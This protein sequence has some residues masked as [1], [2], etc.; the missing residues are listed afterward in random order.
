MMVMNQHA[1]SRMEH[2]PTLPD[3]FDA[4]AQ[5]RTVCMHR[6]SFPLPRCLRPLTFTHPTPPPIHSNYLP[7]H[8]VPVQGTEGMTEVPEGTSE[9]AIMEDMAKANGIDPE[10]FDYDK[11]LAE[12]KLEIEGE[13]K[14]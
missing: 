6:S 7:T 12:Q 10:N 4:C 9:D 2:P 13:D 8:T 11:W 1:Q 5:A 3:T 14:A